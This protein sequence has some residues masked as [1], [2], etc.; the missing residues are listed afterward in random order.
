MS[1]KTKFIDIIFI[2]LLLSGAIKVP[3]SRLL[4]LSFM[5]KACGIDGPVMSASK[6]ATLFPSLESFAAS[7]LVTEDLPTP[8]LPDIIA[9]VFFIFDPSFGFIINFSKFIFFCVI[10]ISF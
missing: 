3:S 2:P 5:P 1:C 7:I 4:T 6:I 9:I 10:S 8:P